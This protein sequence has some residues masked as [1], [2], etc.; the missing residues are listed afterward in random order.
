[1][2]ARQAGP[3]GPH[4]PVAR[5]TAQDVE[6]GKGRPAAVGRAAQESAVHPEEPV[7]A[8]CLQTTNVRGG[9]GVL[10]GWGRYQAGVAGLVVVPVDAVANTERGVATVVDDDLFGVIGVHQDLHIHTIGAGLQHDVGQQFAVA[11]ILGHH[12]SAGWRSRPHEESPFRACGHVGIAG[13]KDHFGHIEPDGKDRG[14]QR[15]TGCRHF[16]FGEAGLDG[17]LPTPKVGIGVGGHFGRT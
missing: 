12:I 9:K 1:M 16:L 13:G 15:P 11:G 17:V 5:R 8:W 6:I 7:L 4:H 10:G 14:V 3:R 2:V